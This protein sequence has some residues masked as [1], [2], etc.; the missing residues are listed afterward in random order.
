MTAAVIGDCLEVNVL[1]GHDHV[2]AGWRAC[3]AD[4]NSCHGTWHFVYRRCRKRPLPP[5]PRHTRVRVH[6]GVNKALPSPSLCCALL[7][8]TLFFLDLSQEKP[9]SFLLRYSFSSF[10]PGL[11]LQIILLTP[12]IYRRA[13]RSPPR[14]PTLKQDPFIVCLGPLFVSLFRTCV[15]LPGSR[16]HRTGTSSLTRACI[17]STKHML[18]STSTHSKHLIHDFPLTF[19]LNN[20]CKQPERR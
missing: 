1:C 19:W 4:L 10:P 11:D 14:G 3:S 7:L 17:S 12:L 15:C 8:A 6:A 18:I 16:S 13:Q 9:P 20:L 5:T 2:P